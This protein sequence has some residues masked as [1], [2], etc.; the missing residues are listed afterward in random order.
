MLKKCDKH[1]NRKQNF[2]PINPS[3]NFIAQQ[4]LWNIQINKMKK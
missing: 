1:I 4:I 3:L 2:F